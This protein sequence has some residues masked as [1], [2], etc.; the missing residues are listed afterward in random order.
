MLTLDLRHQ[1]L[2]LAIEG[3]GD[4][5]TR[6]AGVV[7]SRVKAE[8]LVTRSVEEAVRTIGTRVPDLM[9]V[10]A[11]LS[12]RD[13][14]ALIEALGANT[15]AAHVQMLTIPLLPRP[16]AAPSRKFLG[17]FR[18]EKTVR[19]ESTADWTASF[20]DQ[21]AASLKRAVEQRGAAAA[22][23]EP[24]TEPAPRDRE[25]DPA[26]TALDSPFGAPIEAGNWPQILEPPSP[27]GEPIP[28]RRTRGAARTGP[29]RS[30]SP[31][32]QGAWAD[33]DPVECGFPALLAR[34]REVTTSG[35]RAAD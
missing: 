35:S 17:R 24:D 31:Q 6:L 15:A 22:D 32:V 11:L 18:R 30:R 7:R 20:A 10:P 19:G 29:Q 23:V 5:T 4:E 9:L 13:E 34:L 27:A 33:L 21:V 25:H 8:L 3:E 14:A 12:L 26:A 1:P 2:I 28:P 16:D